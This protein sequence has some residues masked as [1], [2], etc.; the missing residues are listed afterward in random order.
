MNLP[1][2]PEAPRLLQSDLDAACA[3]LRRLVHALSLSVLILAG[4]VFVYLYRQV[5]LVRRQTAELAHYVSEMDRAGMPSF[6]EQ[7]RAK[8]FEFRKTHP[9]FAPIYSRYFGTNEPVTTMPRVTA[10]PPAGTDTDAK[11]PAAR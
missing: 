8:F 7:V 4:T 2:Y 10:S 3:S 6:V 11:A 5:I 9:D 1:E